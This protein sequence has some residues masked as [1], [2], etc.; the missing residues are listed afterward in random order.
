M[1]H[2]PNSLSRPAF[3]FI[4]DKTAVHP[5]AA[6]YC[7][8]RT[9]PD[10]TDHTVDLLVAVA[11]QAW[12]TVAAEYYDPH[13]A[14]NQAEWASQ[15][16]SVMKAHGGALHTRADTYK[17]LTELVASLGDK[18]STFLDPSVSEMCH[19]TCSDIAEQIITAD[20]S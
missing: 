15:L 13:G 3:P 18:Y 8:H 1:I 4:K 14:F 6:E 10:S 5:K 16:L 9:A 20:A 19:T 11:V 2:L 12:Q 17:A 7:I